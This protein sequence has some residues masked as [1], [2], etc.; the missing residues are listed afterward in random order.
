MS[1]GLPGNQYVI[2]VTLGAI[3]PIKNLTGR[4]FDAWCFDEK[5]WIQV[6][7]RTGEVRQNEEE[8]TIVRVTTEDLPG[9]RTAN[10]T[11]PFE[12]SLSCS[13]LCVDMKFR[14]IEE[15]IEK[16]LEVQHARGNGHSTRVKDVL[17]LPKKEVVYSFATPEWFTVLHGALIFSTAGARA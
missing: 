2:D 5:R 4:P 16:R 9:V 1:F 6:P 7:S 11:I 13:L 12:C 17:Q 10:F 8:A 3:G 15:I 14:G